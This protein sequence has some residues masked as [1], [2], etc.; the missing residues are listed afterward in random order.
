MGRYG[1]A[2][3]PGMIERNRTR[4]E[5]RESAKRHVVLLVV[6]LAFTA[7]YVACSLVWVA[8]GVTMSIAGWLLWGVRF[9]GAACLLILPALVAHFR[10]HHQEGFIWALCWLTL[11]AIDWPA[12][13]FMAIAWPV[14]LGWALTRPRAAS[15]SA[16]RLQSSDQPSTWS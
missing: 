4:H 3:D 13:A 1:P 11:W 2:N 16:K 14:A 7:A 10:G 15:K 8:D 12:K 6:A 5:R 9:Y